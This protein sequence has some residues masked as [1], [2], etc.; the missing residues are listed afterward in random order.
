MSALRGVLDDLP[1]ARVLVVGDA[2]L[3]EYLQGEGAGLAR[4]APVPVVA[5]TGSTAAP[6][7]AGNAAAG[8]AALGARVALLAVVGDDAE[9][10][11]LL[12]A[13]QVAGVEVDDV[14]RDPG[15]QTVAKRRVVA[16]GQTL[17]RLDQGRR[18]PPGPAAAARLLERL[19]ALFAAADVVLVSDYGYGLLT[20]EV[21]GALGRLQRAS[22]RLLVVDAHDVARY[23]ALAPTAVTPSYAEVAPLLDRAPDG[24][25][26]GRAARVLAQRERLHEVTGAAVVAVTLDRDG[27]VVCERGRA[28]HRTWARPAPH[29]RACGAGDSFAGALALALAAGADVPAAAEVAQAAA[30]VVTARE[31]TSCCSLGDLREHLDGPSTRV[32]PL[33]RVV[34]RVAH[35]RRQ[36]RRVVFTNGCFDVLHRGHTDLL[37][38]A[39]ALGEVLVVGLNSDAGVRDLLGPG[40]PLTPLE[41]RARVLAALSA[42]DHLVAFDTPTAGDLVTALRPDVFVKGGDYTEEV[43]PEAGCVRACGGVVRILPYLQDRSPATGARAVPAAGALRAPL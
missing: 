42:V 37:G 36:G 7:G 9:G 32:E 41:D 29:S 17:V 4:E 25:D 16:G 34:E 13:L 31:G 2:L 30:A 40:H 20:D 43:V 1:G 23:R 10:T 3:D 5:L 12:A 35:H 27:A 33:A 22:P 15:R 11:C 24:D 21:V 19:P 8:V 18:E 6:G 28:P 26:G 14:L 39:K 38:H